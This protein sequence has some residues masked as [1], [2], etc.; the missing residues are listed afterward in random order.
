MDETQQE[1][2]ELMCWYCIANVLLMQQEP[3]ELKQMTKR[4]ELRLLHKMKMQV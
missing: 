1:P 3:E 2:E 4:Q